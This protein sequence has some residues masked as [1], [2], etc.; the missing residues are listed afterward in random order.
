MPKRQ[1]WSLT[2]LQ[3]NGFALLLDV[4]NEQELNA[5]ISSIEESRQEATS[6]GIR[7]LMRRCPAV[8]R[9]AESSPL[10]KIAASVL[11]MD[12]RPVKA[13]LF[14]KTPSANWYVTWH[15]DLTI[16]VKQRIDVEGFGPWSEK[17]GLPHVQPPATVLEK[18]V[19][20]RIH[21]DACSE[22]NGAIKFIPGSHC[23][24]IMNSPEIE[25][26]RIE[27]ESICCSA[28]RGDIIAMSPLILH[29]SSR[30]TN[31]DHR[32]VLH[33]EYAAGDL[34]GELEWAE[35]S[36]LNNIAR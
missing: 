25:S 8:K 33:I 6:P 14:D 32:R 5:L 34:P 27:H 18:M 24:G 21:L 12:A 30:S 15:Q 7:H 3:Q 2:K 17:E 9:F 29:S 19:S 28:N 11:G 35:G 16:A 23:V 31:P 22:Q 26:C 10:L 20:L 13:I 4:F 1:D 36:G